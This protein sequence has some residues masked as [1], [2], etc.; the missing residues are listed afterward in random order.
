MVKC[1]EFQDPLIQTL[2]IH[3]IL[4]RI[5][6]LRQVCADVKTKLLYMN[7]QNSL[8]LIFSAEDNFVEDIVCSV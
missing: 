5:K 8:N 3:N 6:P 7:C 2:I 4:T 1:R